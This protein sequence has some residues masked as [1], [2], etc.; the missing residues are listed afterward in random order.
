MCLT[1]NPAV[2]HNANCHAHGTA[3][4]HPSASPSSSSP[5][6]LSTAGSTPKKGRVAEPGLRGVAPG[7]GVMRCEPVSV[8]HQVSTIGHLLSP[9]TCMTDTHGTGRHAVP[10]RQQNEATTLR[11]A[12][13]KLCMKNVAA[14]ERLV[15]HLQPSSQQ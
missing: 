6:S 5:F 10:H 4:A 11:G 15:F 3:K 7:N 12:A 2:V 14:H 8:C 1:L 13:D 9:T